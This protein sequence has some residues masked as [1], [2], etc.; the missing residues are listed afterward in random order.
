MFWGALRGFTI[1]PLRRACNGL[2]VTLEALEDV[3]DPRAKRVEPAVLAAFAALHRI[4]RQ[5]WKDAGR[6]EHFVRGELAP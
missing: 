4:Y 2:A 5:A 6:P 1:P 3:E